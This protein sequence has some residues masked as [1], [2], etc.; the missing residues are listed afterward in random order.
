M[1]TTTYT[2]L[3]RAAVMA[4]ADDA[5]AAERVAYASWLAID[6]ARASACVDAQVFERA[7]AR[8]FEAAVGT[9]AELAAL[10]ADLVDVELAVSRAFRSRDES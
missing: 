3:E 1:S 2:P 7:L 8:A 10:E 9:P 6:C 5:D 4:A